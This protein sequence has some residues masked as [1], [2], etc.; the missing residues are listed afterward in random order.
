[1]FN[2]VVEA[3]FHHAERFPDRFCLADDA[4]GVTW[5]GYAQKISRLA[6]AFS[7]LGIA[8][9]GRVVVEACQTVGYLA[10]ELALQ[11]IG[12]VFVPLEHNCAADK[13]AAVARRVE[14]SALIACNPPKGA[15]ALCLSYGDLDCFSGQDRSFE[16]GPW[17]DASA[18]SEIL[19]STGTTGK[20]KGIILTHAAD[21]ALAEN[22]IHGVEMEPD[23][24]E[25]IP[26]PMNHSHGLRRYYANMVN[27]SAVVLLGS[28]MDMR[29]FFSNMDVYRV[30]SLDLVPAAL[31]L[32]LK[33]SRGGLAAYRDRL[34]YIQFGAAPMRDEDRREICRLLPDTRLYN[35]YGSTESGCVAIYNFN[36]PDAKPNC[37]GRPACNAE[38]FFTDED[39]KRIVPSAQRPGLLACSGPMNMLGYWQ[40][41]QETAAALSCGAVYSSDEAY[42]DAD[43]DIILLG[44]RGDVI[45]VGGSKVAPQEIEDAA[46]AFSG[47]ADCGAIPVPDPYK[48]M[49]PKLFV[50]VRPGCDVDFA[51]L[52]AFLAERLEGYKL[53]VSI[54]RIDAIPRSFNGKLLRN[55]LKER[56]RRGQ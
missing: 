19:F 47:V 28:A 37:I 9:G 5:G 54:E 23:N 11:R 8:P 25:M 36:R 42:P 14:A 16:A 13:M 2:S 53:P 17:P 24:V 26:S 29:R 34:R 44:R 38:I 21:I 31:T 12:A 52:R 20:E 33:L 7:S 32:V 39:R 45:N 41:P 30:N 50:Q 35:F 40:D 22:V 10:A 46:R 6:A 4:S 49:A 55:V 56:E 51:A 1:M 43:G 15:A 3:V 18:V 48:G 27:G